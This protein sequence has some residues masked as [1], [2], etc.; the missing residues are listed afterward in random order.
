LKGFEQL[1]GPNHTS[2]LLAANSLGLL[3]IERLELVQ[4]EEMFPLALGGY[5]QA[6]GFVH[7]TTLNTRKYLTRKCLHMLY[8]RQDKHDEFQE[9]YEQAIKSFKGQFGSNRLR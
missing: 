8:A 9:M 1:F 7:P 3:Y 6:F 2:T 5:E 4:A